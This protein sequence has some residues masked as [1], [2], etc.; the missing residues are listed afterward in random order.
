MSI[1]GVEV[2]PTS[3][4]RGSWAIKVTGAWGASA[5]TWE[6]T[7]EDNARP[8][9]DF[10]LDPNGTPR[11]VLTVQ[12]SGYTRS[13]GQA[14]PTTH[15]RTVVATQCVRLPWPGSQQNLFA[16][17]ETDEGEGLRSVYL[18]LSEPIHAGETVT[19]TF[20]SGWRSGHPGAESVAVVNT[21]D[22]SYPLPAFR[23]AMPQMMPVIGTSTHR[24][25]M[26]IASHYPRHF[27]IVHNQA[28]AGVLVELTDTVTTKQVWVMQ[29]SVSP[30][31]GDKL[32]CW[33]ADLDFTGLNPG[34][35]Q[36]RATIYPWI[37]APRVIGAALLTDGAQTMSVHPDIPMVFGY[38]PADTFFGRRYVHIDSAGTTTPAEVTVAETRAAAKAGTH[39]ASISVA[40]QAMRNWNTTGY[41]QPASN[42]FAAVTRAAT[43][44]ECVLGAGA[45]ELG[46]QAVSTGSGFA[47]TT[48][49]V[50]VR[51]DPTDP[52][53][54]ANC[55]LRSQTGGPPSLRNIAW[56]VCDAR[57]ELGD[58][59]LLGGSTTRTWADNV[60][61]VQRT[62]TSN[63][64]LWFNNTGPAAGRG[65]MTLTRFNIVE[66]GHLIGTNA[67]AVLLRS[68]LVPTGRIATGTS[69][70]VLVSLTAVPDPRHTYVAGTS[71][72]FEHWVG[73]AGSETTDNM[74]WGLTSL[75]NNGRALVP[76]RA[77]VDGTGKGVYV[78]TVMVNCLVAR[79]GPELDFKHIQIGENANDRQVDCIWESSTLVGQRTSF[80][81]DPPVATD[82]LVQTGVVIR[83]MCWDRWTS[84]NDTFVTASGN[85]TG[86]WPVQYGVLHRGNLISQRTTLGTQFSNMFYG[87][88]VFNGLYANTPG[89]VGAAAFVDDQCNWGP[90]A[91]PPGPTGVGAGGGDYR[92]GPGS[93]LLGRGAPCNTDR[94]AGGVVRGE[95]FATGALEGLQQLAQ[96]LAVANAF[97]GLAGVG[98]DVQPQS[99]LGSAGAHHAVLAAAAVLVPIA[100]PAGPVVQPRVLKVRADPRTLATDGE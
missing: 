1:A 28:V 63:Q 23:W 82:N 50:V 96:E 40:L 14:V 17:D 86:T 74:A 62:G 67:R 77:F 98:P 92:P 83:N 24:I 41:S 90:N 53:P 12:S 16:L 72:D 87:M 8:H 65:N 52:D 15:T 34:M 21:S 97:H 37:G 76:G 48:G 27:G 75:Y 56:H 64:N 9:P 95:I 30:L 45:Q 6:P 57:L 89:I 80:H 19:A 5:A 29:D 85:R 59:T 18:A 36:A 91:V 4:Y 35:V 73:S 100:V 20:A 69:A 44:W 38:D 33:G 71:V 70:K 51:G 78:R 55:I 93:G 81:N 47:N 58:A 32:F 42:G 99:R 31:F 11:V 66:Y 39:A 60:T 49:Y 61:V 10:D 46:A 25:D 2:L 68:G 43:Y 7:T 84:K 79:A 88:G 54:R 94:D 22:A 3:D 13:G 26:L